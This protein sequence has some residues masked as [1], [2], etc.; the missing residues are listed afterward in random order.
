MPAWL[1]ALI[2]AVVL[3]AAG[4]PWSRWPARSRSPRRRRPSPSGPSRASRKTSRPS[5]GPAMT[6]PTPEQL[7]AEIEAQRAQ[8]ADTVDQ[9]TQK[10]DVKA[11]A[12][13][14][15]SRASARRRTPR[16]PAPRSWSAASC[17]GGSA[18][19]SR[20]HPGH[21]PDRAHHARPRRP[22]QARRP[23]RPREADL[24]VRRE[25]GTARVRR[26]PVHRPRGGAD[27]LRR[28]GH[29]PGRAGPQ[30]DPRSRRPVGEVGADGPRCHQPP[31]L[32][33]CPRHDRAHAARARQSQTAGWALLF[34]R[35]W[36]CGRRRATSA[37][38]AAR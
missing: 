30:R 15:V 36:P 11:Q 13:A 4:R 34:G 12:K 38:S 18:M 31:R 21:R 14:R 32:R 33:G 5:R 9:L 28:P 10:L 20:E 7:E 25:E 6:Q 16:S 24:V 17:G 35:C 2:V 27:L 8:L 37:R 22:A 23:D 3:L 26:R 1:A 19:T 29:L